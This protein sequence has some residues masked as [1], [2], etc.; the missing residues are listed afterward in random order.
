[1]LKTGLIILIFSQVLLKKNL[2][3]GDDKYDPLEKLR[4]KLKMPE[5]SHSLFRSDGNLQKGQIILSN[6]DKV[7]SNPYPPPFSPFLFHLLSYPF[8]SPFSRKSRKLAWAGA[9]STLL[10]YCIG[11]LCIMSSSFRI[12]NFP[13]N[14]M[15]L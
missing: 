3:D 14:F 2:K 4:K 7:Q 8:L 5:K 9:L 13:K 11:V 10:Y 1:M 15:F 6:I 12:S